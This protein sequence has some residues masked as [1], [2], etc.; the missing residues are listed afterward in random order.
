[1]LVHAR[2]HGGGSSLPLDIIVVAPST[3]I[4]KVMSFRPLGEGILFELFSRRKA[5]KA[6]R[7]MIAE[8]EVFEFWKLSSLW[9]NIFVFNPAW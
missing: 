5:L 7:E 6:K 9:I 1:M 3:N 4:N 2:G 8:V